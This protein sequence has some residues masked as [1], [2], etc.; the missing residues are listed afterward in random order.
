MTIYPAPKPAPRKKNPYKKTSRAQENRL[1]RKLGGR[2]V[3]LSGGGGI[4]GDVLTKHVLA[5]CKTSHRINAKGEKFMNLEKGWLIKAGEEALAEGRPWAIIEIRFKNDRTSW[6][7][8][9]T[10]KFVD[11]LLE[12]AAYREQERLNDGNR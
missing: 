10:D 6:T 2:R 8:M 1:A 5:E 4:L 3:P 9:D 7:L 11:L 12:N